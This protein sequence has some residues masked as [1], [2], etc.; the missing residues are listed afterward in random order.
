MSKMT[1]KSFTKCLKE[2]ASNGQ[3]VAQLVQQALVFGFTH[4]KTTSDSTYLSQVVEACNAGRS[5]AAK[6]VVEYITAHANIRYTE[7]VNA[8]GEKQNVF[9]I[10]STDGV[11]QSPKFNMP[12]VTCFEWHRSKVDAKPVDAE[13]ILKSGIRRI[14]KALEEDKTTDAGAAN[15][16]LRGLRQTLAA[17]PAHQAKKAA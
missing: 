5:I 8:N 2:I 13:L 14:E 4:F 11:K 9:K 15:V 12:K 16:A 1:S 17:M 3:T 7:I 10:L 6:H